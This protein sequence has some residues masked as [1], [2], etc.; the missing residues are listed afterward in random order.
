MRPGEADGVDYI[1]VSRDEFER[2]IREDELVEYAK[3]YGE[4]KGVP[5]RQ[6]EEPLKAGKDVML[7]VD[8]QGASTL[9]RLYGDRVVSLFLVSDVGRGG[10]LRLK[11]DCVVR[12]V[13]V[14][15]VVGF[16]VAASDIAA[17]TFAGI[18]VDALVVA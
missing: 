4:Y 13:V 6:L 10:Q 7:Q 16:T 14:V 9:R 18:S 2:M 3:V 1:F 15:V 5:R 17:S 8:V 12:V 11:L